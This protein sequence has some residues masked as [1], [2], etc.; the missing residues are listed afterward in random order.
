MLDWKK[1]IHQDMS[2]LDVPVAF[3]FAVSTAGC[4]FCRRKF[5]KKNDVEK[6][7]TTW[8]CFINVHGIGEF[9]NTHVWKHVSNRKHAILHLEHLRT[10]IYIYIKPCN[11]HTE[12]AT[13]WPMW[14]CPGTRANG[15]VAGRVK[16]W[17]A[18]TRYSSRNPKKYIISN[19]WKA[20]PALPGQKVVGVSFIQ[21]VV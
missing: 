3:F 13:M 10:V 12:F 18:D 20:Q 1:G 7:K 6:S 21:I 15:Q 16:V 11:Y 5:G 9:A 4:F 19:T 14:F 2:Y 17:W 8:P